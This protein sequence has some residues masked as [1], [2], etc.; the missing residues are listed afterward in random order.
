M[1]VRSRREVLRKREKSPRGKNPPG[2]RRPSRPGERG[3]AGR[4]F[5]WKGF[6]PAE[7][8]SVSRV[9]FA[10]AVGLSLILLGLAVFRHGGILDVLRVTERV[11]VMREEVA[12]LAAENERLRGEIRRLRGDPR[13]VERIAR[14][15]LGLVRPGEK[16]YEFTAGD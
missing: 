11:S 6:L 3:G 10:A 2:R 4:L 15:D 13:E 9:V 12:G 7:G 8:V 5:R 1:A 16:V 14:D